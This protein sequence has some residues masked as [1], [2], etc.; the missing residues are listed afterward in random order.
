MQ[1]K[2]VD[3]LIVLDLLHLARVHDGTSSVLLSGDA[4]FCPVV[5]EVVAL[6]GRVFVWAVPGS[7]PGV[8][9]DL[10]KLAS[11]VLTCPD[12]AFRAAYNFRT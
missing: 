7:R 10:C 5:P 6:G 11:G 8:S 9:P 1:Q 12:A 2:G 4:D 3:T